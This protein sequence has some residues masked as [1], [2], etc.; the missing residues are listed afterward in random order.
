MCNTESIE[1]ESCQLTEQDYEKFCIFSKAWKEFFGLNNWNIQIHFDDTENEDN[2]LAYTT[3]VADNHR[4]DIYLVSE[5]REEVTDE[6]LNDIAF[7][8]ICEVLLARV[9][10]LAEKRHIREGE[11]ESEIH[12]V[13]RILEA[14]IL[15]KQ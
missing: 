1:K 7:H 4:A 10:Y 13:I 11:V 14:T 15:R 3:F 12:G 5:W 2:Y 8:E 6:E 9:R